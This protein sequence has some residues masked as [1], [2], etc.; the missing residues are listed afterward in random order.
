MSS[1]WFL[2]GTNLG[3]INASIDLFENK[4][5]KTSRTKTERLKK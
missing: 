2:S 3:I 5:R 1:A 4:Y